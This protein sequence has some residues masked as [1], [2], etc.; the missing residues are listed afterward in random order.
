MSEEYFDD[1]GEIIRTKDNH[2]VWSNMQWAITEDGFLSAIW[3]GYHIDPN[4]LT[5]PEK[6]SWHDHMARKSWIDMDMF[7]RAYRE[8][9]RRNGV[10][11]DETELLAAEARAA[12]YL[13]GHERTPR[14][15]NRPLEEYGF[16]Q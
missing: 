6:H 16:W 9:L 12:A 1:D 10:S 13:V 2:V 7:N 11:I 4:S 5:K 15:M 8:V 14:Y 3:C